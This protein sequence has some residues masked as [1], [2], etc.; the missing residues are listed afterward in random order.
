MGFS[1]KKR[2]TRKK[3]QSIYVL[4]LNN[5]FALFAFFAAKELIQSV[6][7]TPFYKHH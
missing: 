3:P 7:Y 5:R 6:T 4:K 2:H 1:R